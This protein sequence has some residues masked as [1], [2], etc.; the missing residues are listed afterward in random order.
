MLLCD[1][2]AETENAQKLERSNFPHLSEVD[3][4]EGDGDGG[5]KNA[6]READQ[7]K[8]V[9]V[10]EDL[11]A[12]VAGSTE[13]DAAV[14]G[15]GFAGGN[16]P[17]RNDKNDGEDNNP[18]PEQPLHQQ[19]QSV[20]QVYDFD[21]EEDESLMVEIPKPGLLTWNNGDDD[22]EEAAATTTLRQRQQQAETRLAP[23]HCTIC[24]TNYKVGSEVVWSSNSAC[25]HVFHQ[26]R[27]LFRRDLFIVH[28]S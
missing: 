2:S 8:E 21:D 25:D 11:E 1:P 26:V 28:E 10:E 9:A 17:G 15:E 18:I 16:D 27:F 6:G 20:Q 5:S 19:P 3:D 24:L 13:N 14:A 22:E 12:G 7:K 23:G 4:D